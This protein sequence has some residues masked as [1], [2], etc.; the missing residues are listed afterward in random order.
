M[1]TRKHQTT[2]MLLL[3]LAAE[4]WR[5]DADINATIKE[6][7]N[8]LEQQA[9]VQPGG[10]QPGDGDGILNQRDR[11]D[12][13]AGGSLAPLQGSPTIDGATGPDIKLVRVAEQYARSNNIDLRRQ[14]EYVRVNTDLA[15]RIADA[16][17]QMQH[18]PNDPVVLEAYENLIKQTTAQYQALVDAGYQFYFFDETND[19]Y[20]GNPWNSMRELHC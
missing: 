19:P 6:V 10:T 5:I 16:Y 11:R 15:T 14:R 17:E 3:H 2:L 4:P 9:A 1:K 13:Y 12:G 7:D 20:G 18:T 8:E